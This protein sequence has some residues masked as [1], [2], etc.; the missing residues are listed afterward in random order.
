M[1]EVIKK[2]ILE[3]FG[4]LLEWSQT[5]G[6]F[7]KEEAPK[8][9]T[10]LL[11]FR[12]WEAGI[13]VA[14]YIAIL[15]FIFVVWATLAFCQRK[16]GWDDSKILTYVLSGVLFLGVAFFG[17]IDTPNGD[18]GARTKIT[19]MVKIKVAPRVFIVDELKD[20]IKDGVKK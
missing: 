15:M 1:N 20:L 19:T 9:V 14:S 10:E 13:G 4:L 18:P 5:A 2:Q 8:Y 7:V 6:A 16:K 12:F 17:W 3:N 11:Q